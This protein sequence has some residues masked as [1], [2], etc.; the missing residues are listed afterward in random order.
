MAWVACSV[1]FHLSIW[2][3]YWELMLPTLS[4]SPLFSSSLSLSL[5]FLVLSLSL[6]IR[7]GSCCPHLTS[8]RC[9]LLFSFSYHASQAQEIYWWDAVTQSRGKRT[10]G[11]NC[12][13]EHSSRDMTWQASACSATKWLRMRML[14][15]GDAKYTQTHT[16][17]YTVLKKKREK[18]RETYNTRCGWIGVEPRAK[19][20]KYF[21]HKSWVNSIFVDPTQLRWIEC[22][23]SLPWKK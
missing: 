14:S 23:L 19:L 11:K 7:C 4:P 16:H 20:G 22:N 18:E 15:G 13:L 3:C 9:K 1:A 8:G 17:I 5:S 6:F 10:V 2:V 12:V 21:T